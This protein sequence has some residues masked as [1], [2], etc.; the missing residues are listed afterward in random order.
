MRIGFLPPRYGA[1][2]VGGA[3]LAARMLAIHFF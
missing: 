1:E 2:I 3:E